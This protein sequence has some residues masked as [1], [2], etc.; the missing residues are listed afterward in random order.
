MIHEVEI[1]IKI[2][3]YYFCSVRIKNWANTYLLWD[4]CPKGQRR[5]LRLRMMDQYL[6]WPWPVREITPLFYKTSFESDRAF[7]FEKTPLAPQGC[8]LIDL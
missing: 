8:R 1:S 2:L 6:H 7:L 5:H 4:R 3:L